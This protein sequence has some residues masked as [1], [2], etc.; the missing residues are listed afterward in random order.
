MSCIIA[1]N[2]QPAVITIYNEM[3]AHYKLHSH[4]FDDDEYY[5]RLRTHMRASLN[6]VHLW[7]V[8]FMVIAIDP[9]LLH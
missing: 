1:P 5:N 9:L 8:S 2:V 4:L 6:C 7:R 3:Q